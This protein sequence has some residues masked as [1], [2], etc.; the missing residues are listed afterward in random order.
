MAI[1]ALLLFHGPGSFLVAA[2][3]AQS[4]HA[5]AV[6]TPAREI[7]SDIAR[8]YPFAEPRQNPWGRDPPTGSQSH[9]PTPR[10]SPP[11]ST[12]EAPAPGKPHD[13]MAQCR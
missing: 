11:H 9:T 4:L 10:P 1:A 12:I 6:S 3:A 5:I 13:L 8:R 7:N 2:I